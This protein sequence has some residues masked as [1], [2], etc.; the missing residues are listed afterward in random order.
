MG[1]PLDIDMV[2]V[3]GGLLD[4]GERLDPVDALGLLAPE[5]VRI[6]N[7]LLIHRLVG[8]FVGQRIG[9]HLGADRIEGSS[10]HLDTSA[11]GCFCMWSFVSLTPWRGH[12]TIV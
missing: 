1:E 2:V 10:S 11:G 12:S 9:G 4:L 3:E 6:D 8:G 5:T 7:R